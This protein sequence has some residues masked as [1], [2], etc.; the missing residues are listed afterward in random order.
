[1]GAGFGIRSRGVLKEERGV[2]VVFGAIII[3]SILFVTFSAYIA[4]WI[5]SEGHRRERWHMEEVRESF[6]ELKSAIDTLKLLNSRTV[7]VKMAADPLPI[8]QGARSAGRLFVEPAGARFLYAESL[9]D[10]N[11]TSSSYR[12]KVVLKFLPPKPLDYLIIASAEVGG[13]AAAQ[14]VSACL[15]VN[16]VICQELRYAVN[17][18]TERYHF[19]ALKRVRLSTVS[20]VKIRFRAAT[21]GTASIRNARIVAWAIP[22]E[23]AENEGEASTST[24]ENRVTLRFTPPTTGDYLI[25]ATANIANTST[26][27]DTKTKLLVNGV[28]YADASRRPT[29]STA[30]Y[31]FGT[32]KKVTLQGGAVSTIVLR[33]EAAG[34]TAKIK[35]AHVAAIRLDQLPN[36]YYAENENETKASAKKWIEKVINQYASQEAEHLI[37][38]TVH[39]YESGNARF[40][41]AQMSED[42]AISEQVYIK[43]TTAWIY[44]SILMMD[45]RALPAG[46]HRDNIQYYGE[47]AAEQAKFGRLI[48]LEI[49]S[50]HQMRHGFIRFDANNAYYVDQSWVYELGAVILV[51]DNAS[52]MVSRFEDVGL[53][54][55]DNKDIYGN[56]LP[57][58]NIRV[59]VH[60]IR[61]KRFDS[62]IS[63]MGTSTILLAKENSYYEVENSPRENVTISVNSTYRGAWAEYLS[64]LARVLNAKGY[65]ASF[66]NSAFRLTILGKRMASGVS[67]ILYYERVTEIE[68]SLA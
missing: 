6:Q 11:T 13:S 3:L 8:F 65:N 45:R 29:S 30:Y 18:P 31:S 22:C 19:S 4:A 32:F 59:E 27:S 37:L 56:P 24:G 52:V 26:S 23:Y 55:V 44:E 48:S 10:D 53:V 43:G 28:L 15:E 62:S 21:P 66:D 54:I 42:G 61:I 16:G 41:G 63:S 2:S 46:S 67:D 51:Q 40:T 35:Y 7:D 68:V 34:G 14:E 39:V 33:Y 25:I 9:G 17:D 58:D 20:V 49:P 38:G 50:L 64:W 1:M 47:S 57:G 12:D 60:F 36:S 5:P